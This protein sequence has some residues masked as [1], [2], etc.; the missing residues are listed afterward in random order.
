MTRGT[1]ERILLIR[2]SS[3]GDIVLTTSLVRILRQKYPDCQIDFLTKSKYAALLRHHPGISHVLEFPDHG[4]I[5]E[6]LKHRRDI[7]AQK[8]DTI[9]DLHKN[10]RTIMLTRLQA[11]TCIAR[12]KKYGLRRFLLVQTGINLYHEI[13]PVYKRYLDVAHS[14]DVQ[15]DNFGTELYLPAR[16]KSNIHEKLSKHFCD[17]EKLVVVAPGAGFSTKRWPVEFYSQVV[18]K[19]I[20]Q[21]YNCCILGDSS[22]KQFAQDVVR[23]NPGCI[24]FAGELS[25]L[26]SA[27]VLDK[28]QKLV[29][30]DSGLMHISEALGTPVVAIFGSTVRELGFFP[31]HPGSKVVENLTIRCRPCSHI[32]RK[33][34]PRGHFNCMRSIKPEQILKEVLGH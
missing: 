22:D 27:A 12:L 15:D 2:L 19:L 24:D 21:G 13:Q 18:K 33:K 8:Y 11:E 14:L 6:L 34:C 16:L 30:N 25:L 3:I 5:S 31:I 28:A 32:G 7:R 23:E 1:P 4:A 10:A 9:L 29:T 20:K 26:G 17:L